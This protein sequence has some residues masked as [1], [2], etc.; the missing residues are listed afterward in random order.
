MYNPDCE[1]CP[2]IKDCSIRKSLK[3]LRETIFN[4]NRAASGRTDFIYNGKVY[5]T[6]TAKEET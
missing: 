1:N 5:D 6:A 3:E 4:I 2:H